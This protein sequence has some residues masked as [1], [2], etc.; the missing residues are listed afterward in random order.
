MKNT[1]LLAATLLISV[2]AYCQTVN[3]APLKELKVDYILIVGT[4]KMMSNKV[5]IAIDFGQENKY[6]SAKDDGRITDENGKPL[7][8]NSMIDALNFLSQYD[9]EFVNAYS[10]TIQNSNV[11]HWVLKKKKHD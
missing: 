6:F 4:A 8:L 3:G 11:L 2:R 9:Y 1:L 5:S 7:I 10:I